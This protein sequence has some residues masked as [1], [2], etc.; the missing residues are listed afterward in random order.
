MTQEDADLLYRLVKWYGVR[1]VVNA[2]AHIVGRAA[3]ADMEL[4]YDRDEGD[5]TIDPDDLATAASNLR[6]DLY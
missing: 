4:L 6:A 2:V 5:D 3:E 1:H